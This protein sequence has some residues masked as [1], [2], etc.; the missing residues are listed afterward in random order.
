MK[1]FTLIDNWKKA[2]KLWSL[3]LMGVVFLLEVV[4][5]I[6]QVTSDGTQD[7]VLKLVL[8][9]LAVVLSIAAMFARIVLQKKLQNARSESDNIDV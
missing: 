7:V 8:G 2:P 5:L 9:S 1:K 3:Q 6:L 4:H